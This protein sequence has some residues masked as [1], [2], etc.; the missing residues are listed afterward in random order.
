[1]PFTYSQIF[2]KNAIKYKGECGL[3]PAHKKF[4]EREIFDKCLRDC[5]RLGYVETRCTDNKFAFSQ[6]IPIKSKPL[7]LMCYR[8]SGGADWQE[9]LQMCRLLI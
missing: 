5:V 9:I 6:K 3:A 1:M 4:L 2:A 7:I 8:T